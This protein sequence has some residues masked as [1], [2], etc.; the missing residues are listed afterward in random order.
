MPGPWVCLGSD[1][2]GWEGTQLHEGDYVEIA[3]YDTSHCRQG[4]AL[5]RLDRLAEKSKRGQW[6]EASFIAVS[7]EHLRWWLDSGEGQADAWQF[8]VHFCPTGQRGCREGKRG[9]GKDFHTDRFR[10]VTVGDLTSKKVDWLKAPPSK[11]Y[12]EEELQRLSDLPTGK[13][14]DDGGGGAGDLGFDE[15]HLPPADPSEGHEALKGLTELEKEIGRGELVELYVIEHPGDLASDDSSEDSQLFREGV[16]PAKARAAG[17]QTSAEDAGDGREVATNWTLTMMA[18]KQPPIRLLREMRTLAMALEIAAGRYQYAADVLAQRLKAL[19]LFQ[20]VGAWNRAQYLELLDAEGPSL[21]DAAATGEPAPGLSSLLSDGVLDF[22]LGDLGDSDDEGISMEEWRTK[23]K[24]AMDREPK[25]KWVGK[26]LLDAIL[27]V[28]TAL[29]N[30]AR[31]YANPEELPPGDE[32]TSQRGRRGQHGDLMPIH[33]ALVVQG[34]EGIPTDNLHWVRLILLGLDFMYCSAWSKAVCVPMAR[35]LT[36]NQKEA[37]KRIGEQVDRFISREDRLPPAKAAAAKLCSKKFDYNGQPVEHMRDLVAEKVLKAWPKVGSAAVVDLRDCLPEEL[38]TALDRPRDFLLPEAELPER[39]RGSKVRASDE[40]WHKIVKAGYDRGMFV[41]V[42]DR[43]VPRDKQGHL[44]TNGAGAVVKLKKEGGRDVEAQRFISVL[45]PTNDVMRLLPGA[46]DKLPYIGQL[47]AILAERDSY[48][49]LDSEDLQSAFNLFRMPLEWAPMFSFAQKVRG[50]ALGGSRNVTL[51]PALRV[52]PMGWTSAVTLIQA[53]IRHIAYTIAKIPPH[54]DVTMDQELPSGGAM[55]ILY[56]VDN[57]DEIRHLGL[58]RNEAKQLCGA[59]SGTLQGGEILG[60]SKILRHAYDKSVELLGL[61]LGLLINGTMPEH[62]LRHWTGKAAFAAAFR[63]PMY[64]ILQEVYGVLEVNRA[65]AHLA[66]PPPVMDE[67]LV[68][69]ALLPLAETCLSSEV[70]LEIS[71]TDASPTGGGCSVATG[72]KDKTLILPDPVADENFCGSCGKEMNEPTWRT[73]PCPRRC[74][75]RCCSL[76]CT[77]NHGEKCVRQWW[78]TPSFGERFSGKS[79]PLTKAVGLKGISTQPPLDYDVG[80]D[81]WDLRTNEGKVWLDEQEAEGDLMWTHWAPSRITFL[82]DR[83][84]GYWDWQGY[85]VD[86][87]T[88]LRDRSHPEGLPK[89]RQHLNV[90]VR[91]ANAL[92]KRAARGLVEANRRGEGWYPLGLFDLL[93]RSLERLLHHQLQGATKG[94]QQQAAVNW[95]VAQCSAFL[96]TMEAGKEKEHLVWLLRHAYHTGCDVRLTD[97]GD[98]I[99]GHRPGPYPAFRWRWKDVLSYRWREPQHIN[100]LEMTAFLTEL[101]RRA[102]DKEELGKRFF[103]VLD[104]LVSFYVLG[105]G[106]LIPMCLWTISKWN[107]SDGASYEN[108]VAALFQYLNALRGRL[109]RTMAELD[110]ELAEYINHL[111][112]EGDAVTLAGWTLSGLKRFFPRCRPHLLT[113]QL[114]LRNW[115]RVHLPQRTSPMTWLGARAMAGAACKVGRPD[116]ALSIFLGFAFFLRTIWSCFR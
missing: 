49:V 15:Q 89:L 56:L 106:R 45:C 51:R 115:Q 42:D 99:L 47:T 70:S 30:F 14:A 5:V 3:C 76:L 46:Q 105:K 8:E 54:G 93:P 53:A 36:T 6:A 110:E 26:L 71:C 86:G 107:F 12:V 20:S 74:G 22:D 13:A 92:A 98:D 97:R 81:Q 1:P 78:H 27:S 58:P 88:K 100:V 40:E 25:L 109:P 7:D 69:T 83:R 102:R 101:R 32:P 61:G 96:E 35:T 24:K 33:P 77:R 63:R 37:I 64:S 48:L 31:T 94:L 95:A 60:D 114:F 18:P 19:E 9:R 90:S 10:V 62:C 75:L 21:L 113:S 112:Q 80:G 17:I 16:R 29:G 68:F 85:W 108:A 65:G 43:E 116:L 38:R 67:V 104:S 41:S 39:H 103:W 73:Y 59:L 52:V 28:K 2:D 4:T 34:L 55:T 82:T 72:F 84:T 91:Q 87:T 23:M 44:I 11:K 66:L 57:N 50:D 111:Y 79:F